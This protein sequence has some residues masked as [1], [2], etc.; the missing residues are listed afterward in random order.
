MIV[1]A[2]IFLH[3]I[4]LLLDNQ[5]QGGVIKF[6]LSALNLPSKDLNGLNDPYVQIFG[7]D[8]GTPFEK[9]GE[10]LVTYG[11]INPDWDNVFQFQFVK[12]IQQKWKFLVKDWDIGWNQDDV[13]GYVE[14]S[15]DEVV[16]RMR[17]N[18]NGT[19]KSNKPITFSLSEPAGG[20]LVLYPV[21]E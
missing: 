2:T 18:G 19:L 4:L 20:V 21:V 12:G 14:I 1:P 17:K 16:S 5:L 3:S 15:V 8:S 7:K 11:T 6:K 13:L 9:L 10:T